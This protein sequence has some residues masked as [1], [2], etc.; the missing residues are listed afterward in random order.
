MTDTIK[1]II[2]DFVIPVIVLIAGLML[3]AYAADKLTHSDRVIDRM[4]EDNYYRIWT[5]LVDKNGKNPTNLEIAT[6][7]EEEN[8]ADP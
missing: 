2:T 8:R 1:K 3:V 4:G 7:Y 6:Y 5:I